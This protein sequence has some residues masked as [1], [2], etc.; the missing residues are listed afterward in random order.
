[1]QD[2]V[3]VWK[4]DGSH[5]YEQIYEHIKE[6]IRKGKLLYREK[7]PSTRSLASYLQVSRST[8]EL[9]YE[10]LLSEGYIESV[11]YRGYFVAR[12]EELYRFPEEGEREG[13]VL[14]T[15]EGGFAAVT[16]VPFRKIGGVFSFG[17]PARRI[18]C[19]SSVGE[20]ITPVSALLLTSKGIDCGLQLTCGSKS[21]NSSGVC[22]RLHCSR[23]L[24]RKAWYNL[25]KA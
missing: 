25:I 3:I 2:L 14:E 9:A 17:R 15:K 8:V 7:L 19:W 5:L 20:D 1:M 6:E 10:Q 24:L 21:N 12:V 16:A 4:N 22:P 18:P 23:A 13:S 11:P